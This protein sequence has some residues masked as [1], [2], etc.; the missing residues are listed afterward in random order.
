MRLG[1]YLIPSY[2][3]SSKIMGLRN[4]V[5][6]QYRIEAALNFMI[7]MTI[8]GFFKPISDININDLI[9]NIDKVIAHYKPFDIY[10]YGLK[11]FKG[12]G[13][14]VVFSREKNKVLWK[15][16]DDC[17]NAIR[18]FISPDC[19]F[20]PSEPIGN[21]F[22]PHITISMVDATDEILADMEDFSKELQFDKKGYRIHNFK[23]YQFESDKW[24]TNDW[25]YT[26]KWQI[27]KSWR[28][29]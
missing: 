7:H 9:E 12:E 20:T 24:G 23:L 16:Q 25:I 11:V 18:P 2:P 22:I 4:L 5:Y 29:T 15:L 21:N 14:G 6:D 10:P 8:K 19:D 17:Y 13:L 1:F 27:L 26:L 3:L 28:L